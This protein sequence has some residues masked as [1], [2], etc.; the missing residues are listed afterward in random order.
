MTFKEKLQR[1]LGYSILH[2]RRLGGVAN[3][4]FSRRRKRK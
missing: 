4:H 2:A 3:E 1:E